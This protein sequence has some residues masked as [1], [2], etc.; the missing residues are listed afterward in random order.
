MT[1]VFEFFLFN[2]K[3]GTIGF[4]PWV[5]YGIILGYDVT[6]ELVK[7]GFFKVIHSPSSCRT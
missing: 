5:Q 2:I 4:V 7:P 1:K 3:D 6:F